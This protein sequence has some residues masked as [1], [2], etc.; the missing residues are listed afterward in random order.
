KDGMKLFEQSLSGLEII[1]GELNQ[2]IVEA[3]LDDYYT[4]LTNAFDDILDQAEE[5]R[6]SVEDEQDF[7]LGATLYRPLSQGIDN[8][9]G[10]YASEDDN[11][12]ATAMMGWGKQAGLS[13][14]RPTSSGLIEFR[15]STF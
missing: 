11:L 12:F 14:E 8:V 9:L 3:L 7:D 6:E 5:M 2:L 13:P 15:E 1:T 4:G 10:I